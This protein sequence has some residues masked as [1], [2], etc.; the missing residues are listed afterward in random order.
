MS[1]FKP[2]LLRLVFTT[3]CRSGTTGQLEIDVAAIE[4]ELRAGL[5]GEVRF[6]TGD[7]G[8]YASDAGNYRM[9]PL[10]VVLP[11]DADDVIHALA[12]CRKYG[13]PVTARGGGTGIPGQ[14]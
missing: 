6:S 5:K 1:K 11:C 3:G 4:A 10:G 8:M 9:I 12:V 14:R 2:K 13:V 7:R